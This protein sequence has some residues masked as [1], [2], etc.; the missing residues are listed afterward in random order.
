MI[1]VALKVHQNEITRK[2]I[3]DIS[4][5]PNINKKKVCSGEK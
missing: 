1:I 5:L 3:F 2:M 4:D